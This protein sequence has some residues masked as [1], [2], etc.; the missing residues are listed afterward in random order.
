MARAATI[1]LECRDG[2]RWSRSV[3]R[4]ESRS[5]QIEAVVEGD[6]TS[7]AWPSARGTGKRPGRREPW[8]L[9]DASLPLLVKEVAVPLVAAEKQAE[10][11]A[12]EVA[13]SLPFALEEVCWDAVV[14]E[15]D[16]IEQRLLLLA[17]REEAWER[18]PAGVPPRGRVPRSETLP[19]ALLNLWPA[20]VSGREGETAVLFVF[21][22]AAVLLWGTAERPRARF[23]HGGLEDGGE[24]ARRRL[25][26][27]C[28]RALAAARRREPA[29]APQ[30]LRV[31]GEGAAGVVAAWGTA[32][33]IP[34]EAAAE[35]DLLAALPV[36]GWEALPPTHR[37][38]VAGAL[39]G[40]AGFPAFA[41]DL[42]PHAAHREAGARAAGPWLRAAAALFLL[43]GLLWWYPSWARGENLRGELAAL[44]ARLAP[45]RA[46]AEKLAALEEAIAREERAVAGIA[47]L[48]GSRANWTNFLVDLQARLTVIE[49]V[50]I[51]A[52]EV[53][54]ED[55]SP[56]AEAAPAEEFGRISEAEEEAKPNV[57]PSRA[58]RL[59]LRGRLLDPD[60]PLQRVSPEM[61][62]RVND[63]LDGLAGSEYVEA[64]ADT[65]FEPLEG[66]LLQFTFT[67]TIDP[68]RRL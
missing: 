10:T 47:D 54:R 45:V 29:G 64:V 53:L 55:P 8:I 40:T 51:D 9:L 38:P 36:S 61:R 43:A 14:L 56:P 28:L 7:N 21:A 63:L 62:A 67:L 44:R 12:G 23:L 22:Q 50:W 49:N 68:E 41:S 59:R 26:G 65:R 25:E 60:H 66:G 31:Y 19:V 3:V 11:V 42:R 17:A 20:C 6:G 58:F 34:V 2:A 18:A 1:H 35:A 46:Q 37:L 5:W 57:R 4:A 52:L 32:G 13:R 48:A 15:E 30:G 39:L 33:G 16:A 27:E 24:A